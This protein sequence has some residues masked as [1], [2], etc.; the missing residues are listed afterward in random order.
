VLELLP[1]AN[2]DGASLLQ[3]SAHARAAG[4]PEDTV[5]HLADGTLPVTRVL[6]RARHRS[7]NAPG[8]LVVCDSCVTDVASAAQ[9]EALTLSTA[10][11]A[12]GAVGVIGTRWPVE[13]L[14]TAVMMFMFH[15]FLHEGF[16]EPADAL[17]QAALW[18]LDPQ[19]TAPPRMPPELARQVDSPELAD[20]GAWAAFVHHGK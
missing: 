1:S 14:S 10:F 15:H 3:V 13:D 20:P 2:T 4:S 5:L 7:P 11:L 19:R 17:R 12:A 8:G 16:P 6:G 9:D 18:M